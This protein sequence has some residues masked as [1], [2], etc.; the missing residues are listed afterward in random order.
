MTL[1]KDRKGNGKTIIS[2][3]KANKLPIIPN[4]SECIFKADGKLSGMVSDAEITLQV[5]DSKGV[6]E[7]NPDATLTL[8]TN[9]RYISDIVGVVK[10]LMNP[11]MPIFFAC[12]TTVKN[13]VDLVTFYKNGETIEGKLYPVQPSIQWMRINTIEAE[14][15]KIPK[16]VKS[17]INE[18]RKQNSCHFTLEVD[19][20]LTSILVPDYQMSNKSVSPDE[21][22]PGM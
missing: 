13:L 19:P 1:D 16:E 6:D 11:K 5:Y 18:I 22:R 12:Q 15:A 20:K 2:K 7:K 9:G 3:P 8:S 21:P 17:R 14:K 4:Q 10:G